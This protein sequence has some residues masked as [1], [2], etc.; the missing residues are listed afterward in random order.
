MRVVGRNLFI[1]LRMLKS[2]G[3]EVDLALVDDEV[4]VFVKH[5]QPGEPPLRASFSGAELD[6]AANWVA[7][8]VVHCYPKSELAKVWAV[9]ATAMAPLAR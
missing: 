5:P 8:C 4:R 3:I 6:R 1:T 2:A 7:A 9:I